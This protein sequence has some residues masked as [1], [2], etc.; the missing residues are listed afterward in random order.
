MPHILALQR[1]LGYEAPLGLLRLV[2]G[3]L[4]PTMPTTRPKTRRWTVLPLQAE[5][6]TQSGG[7]TVATATQVGN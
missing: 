3:T 6:Y 2:R 5:S 4:Y 1:M 7:R